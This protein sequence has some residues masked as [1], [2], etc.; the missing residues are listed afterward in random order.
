MMLHSSVSVLMSQAFFF[1]LLFVY[2][3]GPRSVSA[4]ISSCLF[5]LLG[6][7]LVKI[8][9]KVEAKVRQTS[10]ISVSV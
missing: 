5:L 2:L 8:T 9:P 3:L 7:F 4:L 10:L 1:F 6:F